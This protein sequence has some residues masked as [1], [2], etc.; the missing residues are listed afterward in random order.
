MKRLV[1]FLLGPGRPLTVVA[2]VA[3]GLC[4]VFLGVWYWPLNVG[5]LV[6]AGPAYT[7]QVENLEITPLPTWIHTDIR[8]DAYRMLSMEGRPSILDERLVGRVHDV[9]ALQPWV[10]KVGNVRKFP[11]ARVVVELDYRRPVCMVEVR[12]GLYPVDLQ[13]VWLPVGDFTA[14]EASRYPRLAGI[15]SVPVGAVGTA[16]G[17]DRVVGGAEVAAA[18]EP[19]W[20]TLQL[21]RIISLPTADLPGAPPGYEIF[22][23]CGTRIHWGHAPGASREGE[24]PWAEKVARLKAYAAENGPPDGSGGA[25]DIDLRGPAMTVSPRAAQPPQAR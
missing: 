17:D 12:G 19:L 7:L 6:K 23:R 13:G 1:E 16:W 21:Q 10:A 3:A 2:A 5:A 22:A 4:L 15:D 25:V 18:V 9:L 11:G 8:S 24:L 14:I 20:T